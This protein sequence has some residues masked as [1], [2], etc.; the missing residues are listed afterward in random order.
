MASYKK[1]TSLTKFQHV[2]PRK[3]GDVPIDKKYI[4]K[5]KPKPEVYKD[6]E[7]YTVIDKPTSVTKRL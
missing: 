1:P 4:K 6:K 7:G 3:L 5:K 2:L